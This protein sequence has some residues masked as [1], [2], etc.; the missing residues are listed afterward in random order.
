MPVL[1]P[2]AQKISSVWACFITRMLW[3]LRQ[4]VRTRCHTFTTFRGFR[5]AEFEGRVRGALVRPPVDGFDTVADDA[6]LI[7]NIRSGINYKNALAV[8]GHAR[9]VRRRPGVAGIE[10]FGR[11]ALSC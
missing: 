5:L 9:V 1:Q 4:L 6:V 7:R 10:A 2:F 8:T 3:K 11:C